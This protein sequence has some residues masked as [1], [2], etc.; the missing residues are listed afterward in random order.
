MPLMDP[1]FVVR[2]VWLLAVLTFTMAVM[3]E[4]LV[5][6]A[7]PRWPLYACEASLLSGLAA[8][9]TYGPR[10]DVAVVGLSAL[11]MASI[12][13]GFIV[14]SHRATG[15]HAVDGQGGGGA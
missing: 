4:M 5:T 9:A 8:A 1:V 10:A 13:L 14:G 12:R 15:D 2:T 11:V 6:R 7:S 3:F